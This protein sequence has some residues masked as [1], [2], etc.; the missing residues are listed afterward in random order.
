[1]MNK[2]NEASAKKQFTFSTLMSN[3]K[4]VFALSLFFAFI[5]WISVSM[6]QTTETERVFT[7]VKINIAIDNNSLAAQNNL[8]V[9]GEN[10]FVADVTVK[11]LSY[12][13]NSSDFTS[14]NINL[15][16]SASLVSAAGT[17]DL[18]VNATLTGISGDAEVISVSV[19]TVKVSFDERVTKSF[20]L[21]DEVEEGENYSLA[22]GLIREN[23]R[24]SK[25]TIEIS[26]PSREISKI[27]G[28]K[29]YVK[30]DKELSETERFEAEIIAMTSNGV[31]DLTNLTLEISEPVYI[32]IPICKVGTYETAVD[33][34]GTPQAYRSEGIEYS[35]YPAKVD[36]SMQ[37]GTGETQLDDNNKILV[38]TID[39]SKV[40]NTVN[41]LVVDNAKIGSDVKNFTV[42]IDMSKMA[43]R[44]LE[45]PV[46]VS[47]VT[48]PENV[49]VISQSVESVQ[50]IGPSSSVMNIDKTAAYA[51]PVLDGVELEKGTYTIPA[52]IILRTLTD[53]W[54]Y[55]SY[56]IEIE[57][58]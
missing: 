41:R 12:V 26:G 48:L 30:V 14:S 33:F 7:D 6:S 11:G 22:E 29:A 47:S 46:D 31:A 28:V 32:S 25:E 24:I 40:N 55:G 45:I 44:W 16:A 5:F 34:I 43:K 51:V 39:F 13:V 15:T 36:I 49:T 57:V 23:A 53:S 54:V 37:T 4:A 50:I 1:M 17:Y 58:K 35:V 8:E 3:N 20:A 2:N 27:T 18:P 38:G 19:K 10:N 42:T 9:I 52:K 21:T 56:S